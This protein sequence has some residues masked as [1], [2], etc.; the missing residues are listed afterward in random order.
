MRPLFDMMANTLEKLSSVKVVARAA[1][2]S[3]TILA[4]VI[5]LASVSFHSQQVRK[6][7]IMLFNIFYK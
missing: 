7:L 3:L 4:H 5:S 1:L 2:A 6:L